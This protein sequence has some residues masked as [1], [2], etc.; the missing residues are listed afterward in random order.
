M[1]KQ[2]LKQICERHGI[3][4]DQLNAARAKGVNPWSDK[5][6]AKHLGAVRHRIKPNAK[7]APLPEIPPDASPE[8]TL[9]MIERRLMDETDHSQIKILKDK[10]AG[11]LTGVKVRAMTRDLVPIGEV[12]DSIFKIVSAARG[13]LLKLTSDLPPQLSGAT[14]PAIQKKL[15]AEII[16]ILTRLS[17]DCDAA[18]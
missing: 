2:T 10:M 6:L 7:L 1:P 13:E 3:T 5:A 17:D 9:E 11:L 14:A 15:R 12:K 18:Y 16:A 4:R 8:Q